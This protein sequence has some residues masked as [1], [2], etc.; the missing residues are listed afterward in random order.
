MNITIN[1]SVAFRANEPKKFESLAGKI[2]RQMKE[3]G[4]VKELSREDTAKIDNELAM[5]LKKIH[6]KFL[7]KS[8]ASWNAV[9]DVI[10][11]GHRN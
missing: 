11:G 6:N 2:I 8:R 9:K 3:D 10:I 1:H 4:R 7:I 5:A